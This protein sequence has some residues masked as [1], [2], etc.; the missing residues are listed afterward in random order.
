MTTT[1]KQ[2][3]QHAKIL[4]QIAKDFNILKTS[5]NTIYI[6]IETEG[7]VKKLER[8]KDYL[9]NNTHLYILSICFGGGDSLNNYTTIARIEIIEGLPF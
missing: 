3:Q 2:Q 4:Q 1:N 5:G 8:L 9:N 7:K 6:D